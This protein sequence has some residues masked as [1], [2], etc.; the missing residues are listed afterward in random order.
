MCQTAKVNL[1]L[2]GEKRVTSLRFAIKEHYENILGFDALNGRTWRL[3]DGSLWS[4][5]SITNPSHNKNQQT[6]TVRVLRAAPALPESKITNVPQYP[7]SAT[8]RTGISE[9]IADLEK[10]QII[11]RTHSPYNSPVWPVR[12]PDGRWRLT[13]DYRRL[14][15]STAPLTAA[16]PNIAALT[17]TLQA[18]AHPWMAV[19]DVKD[20]FF[21]VP[22]REKDRE[23]FAFTWEGI[24]YTFNRLPQGYKHS[25]TIAHAALAELLQTVS[26]P[27]DVKLYQYIDDILIGGPSPDKVGEV[28]AT[29][30]Q[31]LHEAKIEIPPEKCQGPSKEVKFLGTWW[32]AGS[33]AI[34]PDT[35][36]KIEQSEMPQSKKEL[37]QLM[38]TLGYWRK[39]VPGFSIIARPL[40]SLLR[41]GKSWRWDSEHEEAIKT[42]ILELKTYQS[43]GPVHPRDPIIAEWGFAE[44]GTY[45]NL[46]QIGPDGPKRPLLFSSTAFKETEQRYSEW[47]KG[48]LSLV[49]AVKQV[50]KIRQE[51]AVQTR[52]PFNLLDTILKGT[53]PP[54]GI[55]QK[56]T[57][58]KWYAYL[59]GVADEMQL[60]EGHTK[61]SKLQMP[62]N[63]DP[64]AL[65]QPFKPSP[66]L[67]APPFTEDSPTEGV[68]FSDASAKRVDG[69]WQYKAVALE[70]KTG[71]QVIEEGE[72]SAQVGELRAVVL[73][74]Q[75]EAK[76]IYVDSYAVWAGATQW[77]CQWEA[78]NWEINK[79]PIWRTE[80]WQLL[81]TIARKTPFQ[82]GW[83]K[84]HANDHKPATNWNQRVDEL[85][86]I[87]K[88]DIED[89]SDPT[90]YRLGEWLHQKL[91]H[92]GRE[93]L[94]FSAQSRGW[95]LSR[96]TCETILTECPQ[97]KLKLQMDHPAKA[98]PLHIKE[99][100]TLWS[101]WQIDYIGPLKSSAGY[102]YILTGVEIISGLLTATKCQKA[103]AQNT[104]RGL[105]SWFSILPVPDSIQSD[106]GS[107]FTS[108][109]VQEWAKQKEIKW[110]FHTPY[111]P[112]SNGIVERA[113]GLLKKYLK[114]HEGQ[115]DRRLS[116]IL[117][118]LNNRYGPY[119]SPITRAFLTLS[120]ETNLNNEHTWS[121]MKAGQPVMAKIPS[122]GT[123]PV[124][125]VKP[126]GF[127]AWDAIDNDGI[128]HK[129]STRWIYPA[130]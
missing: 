43:L 49:R 37:Q 34:P 121:S 56:P 107:H 81:L 111:Y 5:G 86:K 116:E 53:A 77:L 110:V 106:N 75:N 19:L 16:V 103:N 80:D 55:A 82:I 10:R 97:C 14:N 7:I 92:T 1:L 68:W 27:A 127:L 76:A 114:P 65:Q 23:K 100:K 59:V 104:I 46:F 78:L 67:D 115:W 60:S 57:I 117:Q 39:H 105:S 61:V 122:V 119:G 13:V 50:E 102:K 128:K 85:T 88:I 84:A 44:H 6:A 112:Q 118:Q 15:A 74:A 22:L 31:T 108:K 2:P 129:I 33:A 48:L 63:T 30:W 66:I 58:R 28:A 126:R 99:G 4:F 93:A 20:M 64:L 71:K 41:K 38:G 9:V 94:Y 125:L 72:G 21:M 123:I 113:N 32:I 45:C 51:Q 26:L 40:Y 42:L 83:V 91:G 12:K 47:E 124:T 24:Q 36:N 87:R 29:V 52:G 95:P 70:I 8:A 120:S 11:S 18:A 89:S 98:P 73:A 101:T 17:A 25:P 35:L 109:E 79:S 90:W 3:P 69:K 54:E 130:S 62:I 96:K